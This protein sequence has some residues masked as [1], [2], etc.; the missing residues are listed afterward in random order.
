MYIHRMAVTRVFRSG[1]SQAVRIPKEFAFP[2]GAEL[3]IARDGETLTLTPKRASVTDVVRQLSELRAPLMKE[4]LER[5]SWPEPR[6][7]RRGKK[8]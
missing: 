2:D 8:A 1:N 3:E 6:T 7:P 5:P 4:A